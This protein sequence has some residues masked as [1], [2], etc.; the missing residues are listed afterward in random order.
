MYLPAVEGKSPHLF[1]L[2]GPP[3]ELRPMFSERVL[4]KLRTLLPAGHLPPGCRV[5]RLA[6]LGESAIEARIGASLAA[7]EGLE[8]GYCARVGEVDVRCIGNEEALTRAEAIIV[9]ELGPQIFSREAE[10]LEA[11]IVRLLTERGQKLAVAES[12][13]GGLLASRITDVPG[14]STVFLAGLTT[15]AA[16]SKTTVLGVD[17]EAVECFGVYSEEVASAMA[18]GAR[19]AVGADYALSTTGIAGPEGGSEQ[20]PAGTVYI[21][22]AAGPEDAPPTVEKHF[23]PGD[24]AMFKRRTTQAALDLLRRELIKPPG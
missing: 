16:A 9:P 22:L 12:C 13:T 4:P 8:I 19:R 6:G 7:V 21:A 17:P 10:E 18:K 20:K 2:P 23:F 15:Y 5:Y 24:R 11:V 3:R 14:A 1:L